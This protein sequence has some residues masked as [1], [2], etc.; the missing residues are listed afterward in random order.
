MSHFS[1]LSLRLSLHNIEQKV[2]NCKC[3][4]HRTITGFI[5]P[6]TLEVKCNNPD[7]KELVAFVKGRYLPRL[8]LNHR[9]F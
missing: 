9:V 8:T 7:C 3:G 4:N 5:P 1:D 6:C 2:P